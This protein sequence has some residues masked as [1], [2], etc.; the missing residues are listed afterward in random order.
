MEMERRVGSFFREFVV[1]GNCA[2]SHFDVMCV[3]FLIGCI[4]QILY[5]VFRLICVM[6]MFLLFYE[7][8][9]VKH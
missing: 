9:N 1:F 7:F 2:G 4:I 8:L 3:F 6:D 5:C